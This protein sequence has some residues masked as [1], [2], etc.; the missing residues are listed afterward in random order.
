MRSN[1]L[2]LRVRTARDFFFPVEP[3]GQAR[4]RT[5]ISAA[6]DKEHLTKAINAFTKIGEK[7][8]ILGKSKEEVVGMYGT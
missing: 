3:K 4:I 2:V 8:K 7:Y 5:Q 6:H 1:R